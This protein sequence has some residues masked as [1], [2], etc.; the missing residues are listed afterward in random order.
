MGQR[1]QQRQKRQQ[2]G[3]RRAK[4][5]QIRAM[6][7]QATS[8]RKKGGEILAINLLSQ[9]PVYSNQNGRFFEASPEEFQQLQNMDVAV[10][11]SKINQVLKSNDF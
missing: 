8:P 7:Q 4:P 5:E 6:S 1:G 9:S 2:G 10:A 3:F 11:A